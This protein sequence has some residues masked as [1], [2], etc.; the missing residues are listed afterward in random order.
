MK[1]S[2]FYDTLSSDYDDMINFE[3]SVNNKMKSLKNF[4]LTEDKFALDLGCGTG[5]DSI[6]LSRLSLEVDAVDHSKGMLEQALINSKKFGVK[7]NFNQSSL[8]E[9]TPKNKSYDL[10]ISLGNTI[11]NINKNDLNRLL[12]NLN[13]FLGAD[14]RIVIQIV[15][16]AK[17]PE[18]GSYILNEFEND[19]VCITRKYSINFENIDFIIEKNDKIN[20]QKSEII[21]KLYPH[22]ENDFREIAKEIYY[23]VEFYG[24]LIKEPYLEDKSQNLVILLSK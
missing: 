22:S 23:N 3:N 11:A 17:L 19:S 14:G 8:T 21:T 7:I 16:Y 5:A 12:K 10:I 13:D 6:T 20:N 18:T 24:N 9:F 15:N 2:N 1:N 4:V